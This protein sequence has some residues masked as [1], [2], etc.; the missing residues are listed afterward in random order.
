M[1]FVPMRTLI[2]FLLTA[3]QLA[4]A[5][6]W[7]TATPESQGLDGS[8]LDAARDVLAARRTRNFLVVRNGHIVYEWYSPDSGPN[9]RHGTASLAKA[10]VGGVSLML[11]LQDG[12]LSVDDP[13]S[14]Y[15]PAWR[16]D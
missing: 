6:P 16:N 14:K 11:A 13:A 8:K 3:C 9:K 15:I 10:L 12:R 5:Q 4:R 1:S 2:A 7:P